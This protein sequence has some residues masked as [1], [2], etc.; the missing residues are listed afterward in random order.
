M[1]NVMDVV[2]GFE[3]PA[4]AWARGENQG[5]CPQPKFVTPIGD[6]GYCA[7]TAAKPLTCISDTKICK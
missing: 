4:S 1:L 5:I 3:S 6:A 7:G 2:V